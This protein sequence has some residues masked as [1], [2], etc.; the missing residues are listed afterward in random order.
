MLGKRRGLGMEG[1][2]KAREIVRAKARGANREEEVGVDDKLEGTDDEGMGRQGKNF[3]PSREKRGTKK[4]KRKDGSG[5]PEKKKQFGSRGGARGKKE[6]VR[7]GQQKKL[8]LP[9]PDKQ[10]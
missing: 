8:R 3:Q 7:I 5:K 10:G 4:I 6:C 9:S 2:G 1:L